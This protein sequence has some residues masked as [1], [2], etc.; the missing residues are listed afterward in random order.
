MLINNNLLVLIISIMLGVPVYAESSDITKLLTK[1]QIKRLIQKANAGDGKAS[2]E[3][4]P[5]YY[6]GLGI[7]SD[8]NKSNYWL[9]KSANQGN[10]EAQKIVCSGVN[11]EIEGYEQAFK[12][13]AIP[14]AQINALIQKANADDGQASLDLVPIY[15]QGLGVSVD[16]D[17]ADYWLLKAANQ[18]NVE[19]QRFLCVDYIVGSHFPENNEEAERWCRRASDQGD[20]DAR[21]RMAWLYEHGKGVAENKRKA[22]EIYRE[23]A[24]KGHPQS[25]TY[26]ANIEEIERN[27]NKCNG[28]ELAAYARTAINNGRWILYEGFPHYGVNQS[29]EINRKNYGLSFYGALNYFVETDR[30][31][32][33]QGCKQLKNGPSKYEL[34]MLKEYSNKIESAVMKENAKGGVVTGP[35]GTLR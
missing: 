7:P 31:L 12:R 24:E 11:A 21:Y 35:Y 33:R 18:G 23:L 25:K 26:L 10:A 15:M 19:A 27:L 22:L 3:L 16:I 32:A 29:L 30:Y 28:S 20:L 13:C 2:L 8:V 4:V 14:I 5:I 34:K 6:Q 9:V 1:S 17:K